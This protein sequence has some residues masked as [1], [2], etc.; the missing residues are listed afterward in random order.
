MFTA[1][2]TFVVMIC[3]TPRSFIILIGK[4]VFQGTFTVR[5]HFF[6]SYL[7]RGEALVKVCST[8]QDDA[9][10]RAKGP[11]QQPAFMA[12]DGGERVVGDVV[13]TQSRG[14]GL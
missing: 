10:F 7:G 4:A 14:Q 9:M 8:L 1:P 6:C 11:H 13:V 12:R 2:A 5:S 3:L